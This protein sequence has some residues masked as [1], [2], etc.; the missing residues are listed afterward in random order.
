MAADVKLK[1]SGERVTKNGGT[2]PGWS[3]VRVYT[4]TGV[5]NANAAISATGI[6]ALNAADANIPALKVRDR[7]ATV[8]GFEIYEV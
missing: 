7:A 4:V 6:P 8:I 5:D 2:L 3:I 1:W